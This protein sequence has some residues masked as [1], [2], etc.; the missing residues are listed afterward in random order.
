MPTCSYPGL[1][2]FKAFDF[3]FSPGIQ[4]SACVVTTHTNRLTGLAPSGDLTL[5]SNGVTLHFPDCRLEKPVI[6]SGGGTTVRLPILDRRW[7][8]QFGEIN[9][10]YNVKQPDESYLRE[11]SPIELAT[12]LLNAMGEQNFDVSRLPN[13]TRPTVLW[14]YANPAQELDKL[15]ESLGCIVNLN[16]AENIVELWP[17]GAARGPLPTAKIKGGGAG[18]S[19][20]AKPKTLRVVGE[21]TIFE[22]AFTLNNPVAYDTDGKLSGLN[23]LSYKPSDGWEK[24]SLLLY[25]ITG[26]YNDPQTGQQRNT[27]DLAAANVWKLYRVDATNIVPPLLAGTPLAP[28][29]LADIELLNT[30]AVQADDVAGD[31]RYLPAEVNGRRYVQD[32]SGAIGNRTGRF[33]VGF[34][35]DNE[36]GLVAFSE[37]VFQY[38]NSL[39]IAASCELTTG[40]HAGRDGIFHRYTRDREI[41]GDRGARIIQRDELQRVIDV[42]G[43]DNVAQLDTEADKILDAIAGEYNPQPSQTQQHAG[44]VPQA[45]D[46]LVRQV[47]WTFNP[48]SGTATTISAAAVHNPFAK[49]DTQKRRDSKNA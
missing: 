40:Y 26:T 17:V 49:T 43:H 32:M 27:R 38:Q 48:G 28:A 3:A 13:T 47:S 35:V 11:K 1:V 15:A 19:L 20:A 41:G 4:P 37:P 12:L 21:R 5:T 36:R 7:R 25:N 39:Y 23:S 42:A 9:G 33:D 8:W 14:E 46:G 18:V 44:L 45:T 29:A 6:A 30:R 16:A 34:N 24:T 2:D 31:P 22:R 10:S